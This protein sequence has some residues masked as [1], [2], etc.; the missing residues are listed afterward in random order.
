MSKRLVFA[1]IMFMLFLTSAQVYAQ[2]WPHNEANGVGCDSCHFIY[3]TE[4]S[5]L[6]PWTAHDPQD[7][8]DTQFNT[9]CWSCHNDIEAPFVNTH[10]SLQTD[11]SYG[12]WSIECRVCH[13]QHGHEQI[14]TYGSESYVY[15]GVSTDMTATTIMQAGAGWAVDEWKGLLVF[16]NVLDLSI[17]YKILSNTSDTLTVQGPVNMGAASAGD[18]FVIVYSKLIRSTVATPNSGG[19]QVRFFDY[20]GPNSYADGD[21]VYDG[22]CE[23]CHTMTNHHRNDGMAPAQ[24]HNDSVDCVACHSHTDGFAPTGGSLPPPHDIPRILNNCDYCH[25][26]TSDFSSPVPD[27]KCNQCHTQTGTL[28]VQFPQDFGSAPNVVAHSSSANGSVNYVYNNACVDCHNPMAAQPNLKFIRPNNPNSIIPGSTIVFTATTGSGSFADGPPYNENICNTCHSMTNHH[29]FDG[30]ADGGQDHNNGANCTTCH[31]HGDGF[32]P[33]ITLPPPHNTQ[34]FLNNCD[35]CHVSASDFTSTIPDTKC[36]QCHTSTGTLKGSFPSAPNVMAHSGKACVECHNPMFEQSNLKFIRSN[37][38]SSIVPG[39]NIVFTARTGLGSFADGA[40]YPENICDTCHSMTNHHQSDGIA[41]G[42]QD[43]NN[44]TDCAV[45]HP[46]IDG[47]APSANVPAPH[48]QFDCT[49]CHVTPDSYVP[50]AAIPNSACLTCH[51]GSQAIPVA[52]HFTGQ[53]CVECHN[54]MSEQINFRGNMNL[55]F[56]RTVIRGNNIAFEAKT[57]PYSFANDSGMPADMTT[58]NYVCNT[59]H[60]NTNHHQSDGIAPGGQSHF[61]GQQCTVCHTHLGSFRDQIENTFVPPPHGQ[62]DCTVCH[63]TPDTYVPNAAIPNDACLS[64]HGAGVVGGSSIKV[65]SHFDAM[66][67]VE[68]HNPM[69]VQINFRGNQNLAFIRNMVRGTNIAFEAKTGPYSFANDSNMPADMMTGN[70]ICNTCHVNTNHHQSDG[71]A[72]GG[73]SHFDGQQCT[74]CHDHADHFV[75]N[76]NVPPPHDVFTDCTVCHV[77]PDTYVPN[78]AIP[79]SACLGCHDPSAPGTGSGGSDTKVGSHYSDNYIDPTTGELMDL[80]CVEC[81]NPMSVQTNFRGNDNLAFIRTTIRGSEIAFEA[82]TGPY[83]FADN[84]AGVPDMNIDNYV[85]NTCHTQT[86]HHQNDGS[87]PGGQSHQDGLECTQC[88]DHEGGFQPSG[89]C[90]ICHSME[91]GNRVA[92]VNQFGEDSHHI[93]GVELTDEHCYQCHWEA[94][95]DGSINDMYHGGPSAP[96]SEINLVVYGNGSRPTSYSAG[97]TA[98]EYMANGSRSEMQKINMV[99]L[100]CHSAQNNNTQPFG[101]GKTPNEYAWDGRSVDERYSQTGTTPWGKYSDTSSTNITPKNTQT[102]AYSGH[103]NAANNERGWNLSET[104]PN[105]SGSVKVI[106]FD[107][108]NSH[109]STVS[110]T[111]TSYTSATTNGA[112]LKDTVAGKGGFSMTYKPEASGSASDNNA[113]NAG[114]DLCFDCHTTQNAGSTPWGYQGTFGSSQPILGYF[115]TIRFGSGLAGPQQRY[116]YKAQNGTA[117]TGHF[118]VSASLST[119]VNGTINGLCTPCHDPHGVSPSL[120][121]NQQYAVPMLKGTWLTSPYKEDAAPGAQNKCRGTTNEDGNVPAFCGA[122]DPGYHIDQNTFTNW[123]YTSTASVSQSVNEFGGLCM[124]CHPKSSLSPDTT[125]QWRSVDRIHNAVKGWDNDGNTKHR[126]TCSKCHTP[127]NTALGRL[128]ITNCLDSAH[129][130]RVA[131][132]GRAVAPTVFGASPRTTAG[133]MYRPGA[134][135]AT[136]ETVTAAHGEAHRPA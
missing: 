56:V 20:T 60:V 16:P 95:S 11:N 94:N 102:K 119:Q 70:Y 110:G 68:C 41:P 3:G 136:S 64:C 114:A 65:T 2:D 34:A 132:G 115:D 109:G 92:V 72:P 13:N 59:C 30:T 26:S 62:F 35:Y 133:T 31:P 81:H 14:R 52:S 4:P 134:S 28:K 58:V 80:D 98:M 89:G 8:D 24:S 6:P 120:G 47:F 78:A 27:S 86:N 82:K 126:Y 12:D 79:N 76:V 97:N 15:E 51:N 75:P 128:L 25:V 83:S 44:G 103:G 93:Q 116:S 71:T 100:G 7:I 38:A 10:S 5:L 17:N 48:D 42:G 105:T 101:D 54:P 18:T 122:S 77:T 127:H 22:I 67:C 36:N 113:H 43:H 91:Q 106:C 69:S 45:C 104:W 87:A 40:P 121:T 107:C 135:L 117:K 99:C 23:V 46:H 49:V 57:G 63:T 50:N 53:A 123:N 1:A 73:Q 74:L 85:C 111:T 33:N 66:A 88:H 37:I 61:D 90:T 55:S 9:L 131:S 29:Q 96:G 129:R 21:T 19:K 118:G 39:A 32:L 130:G 112:M 108:H 125:S 84:A 124:T